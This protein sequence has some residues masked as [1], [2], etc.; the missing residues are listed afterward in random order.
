MYPKQGYPPNPHS[1]KYL[2]TYI[3]TTNTPTHLEW[4]NF[5]IDCAYYDA[6]TQLL[7]ELQFIRNFLPV[8]SNIK[9]SLVI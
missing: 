3:Y 9:H 1:L 4:Q 7:L 6:V 8:L 5:L 2:E